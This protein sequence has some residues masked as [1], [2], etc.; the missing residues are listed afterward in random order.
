MSFRLPSKSIF[1]SFLVVALSVYFFP[2][3]L[4]KIVIHKLSDAALFS[5][6]VTYEHANAHI[7]IVRH[8]HYEDL[9][10]DDVQ[11]TIHI[12]LMIV[13]YS[14]S[15]IRRNRLEHILIPRME[16]TLAVQ[17]RD[18]SAKKLGVLVAQLRY[19]YLAPPARDVAMDAIILRVKNQREPKILPL[20]AFGSLHLTSK[21]ATQY[22]AHLKAQSQGTITGKADIQA[23]VKLG[24]K[25][26]DFYIDESS[27][28]HIEKMTMKKEKNIAFDILPKKIKAVVDLTHPKWTKI[29]SQTSFLLYGLLNKKSGDK[30]VL[31]HSHITLDSEWIPELE[32][33]KGTGKLLSE[34]ISINNT[35]AKQ[36][37]HATDISLLLED[38]T[39]A[40]GKWNALGKCNLNI[41]VVSDPLLSH[42]PVKLQSQFSVTQ[43]RLKIKGDLADWQGVFSGNFS[44]QHILQTKDGEGALLLESNHFSTRPLIFN[45]LLKNIDPDLFFEDGDITVKGNIQWHKPQGQ[46]QITA[47][48]DFYIK[49]NQLS[50]RYK[51]TSFN[52]LNGTLFFES[53]S[54]LKSKPNQKITLAT[55]NSDLKLKKSTL[56]FDFDKEK[57]LEFH[58]KQCKTHLTEGTLSATNFSLNKESSSTPIQ[59]IAK[60]INLEDIM[61]LI[62][63]KG[64]SAKGFI[65]GTLPFHY[66]KG[67]YFIKEGK[68]NGTEKGTIRYTPGALT[69]SFKNKKK[70]AIVTEVLSNFQYDKLQITLEMTPET[71]FLHGI[72]S[73]KNPDFY[74]GSLPLEFH[75]RL[76]APFQSMLDAG[77]IGKTIANRYRYSVKEEITE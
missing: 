36:Q 28:I 62:N 33:F 30:R 50:G 46:W 15:S 21:S 70:A 31:D 26:L 13:E 76:T 23:V 73:G 40:H 20:E 63:V 8:I 17:E 6:P 71:S 67:G 66:N 19:L 68:F 18:I 59:I 49:I 38:I 44:A 39:Y 42:I 77:F 48:D 35:S 10:G 9:L 69:K 3:L 25:I 16:I 27:R 7:L 51:G 41:T 65:N 45:H 60:H 14:L 64:L 56:I 74:Q 29:Q 1:Y 34:K 22:S 75:L 11:A 53:L 55:L 4:D 43:D 5:G 61:T 52:K 58:I 54:P 47:N 57:I 72:I 12:P 37:V 2:Y 24:N 32:T